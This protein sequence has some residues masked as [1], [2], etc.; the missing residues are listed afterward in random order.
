[1]PTGDDLCCR[2]YK[3]GHSQTLTDQTGPLTN[4]DR[5]DW[6]THTGPLTDTD[7]PDWATHRH[8]QTRLGH[9]QTLTDQ[10]GPL[11]DT[12]RPDW[13]THRHWQTR[14]GHS[15]TLTD[16]TG[17]LTDIDRPDWAIDR[18]DWVTH[19]HWQTRLLDTRGVT[20]LNLLRQESVKQETVDSL[21]VNCGFWF[22]INY[23][24]DVP[25]WTLLRAFEGTAHGFA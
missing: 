25:G 2:L 10:T 1:M 17:P 11:T 8:W 21:N 20:R 18:P 14:L 22:V 19:R 13:A 4:I 6:A 15:Q 7:R 23:R 24:N 9:S 16:Q 5:P 3:L 12:D